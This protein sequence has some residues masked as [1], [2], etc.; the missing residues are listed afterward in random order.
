MNFFTEKPSV[1]VGK[2]ICI[3]FYPKVATH[4]NFSEHFAAAKAEMGHRNF[5]RLTISVGLA[6]FTHG[7][8]FA[9]FFFTAT[10]ICMEE[11]R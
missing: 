5:P 10:A 2:N 8:R 1:A 9:N 7:C 3:P 11:L 6:Q 4:T